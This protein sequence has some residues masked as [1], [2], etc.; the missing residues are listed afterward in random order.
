MDEEFTDPFTGE[1]V[2]KTRIFIP[3]NLK[4]N[5]YLGADYVAN[6][7]QAGSEELV[8]AWLEGDWSVIEGAYFDWRGEHVIRACALPEHWLRFRSMDWGSARPFSV[9]WWA[10]ASETWQA[11][12]GEVIPKG[13]MVRFREWYGAKEPNVGLKMTTEAVADGVKERTAEDIQYTV[14]DPAM[15]IADGGPSK[16]E[17]F[18]KRGVPLRRGDNKRI[19]GWEQMR[20]RMKGEDGRPMLYVFNTCADTIRTVPALQHDDRHPEDLD[21]NGEDHAAD[22]IRYACMSRPYTRPKD[23]PEDARFERSINEMIGLVKQRRNTSYG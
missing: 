1:T 18:L 9:G 8:R 22:E 11:P 2:T 6:L 19:P 4:D 10:T 12:T 23:E 20:S 13:A 14:V 7:F 5:F 15:F 21:T 17:T 16:A 3:S